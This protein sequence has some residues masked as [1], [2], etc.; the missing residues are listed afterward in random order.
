MRQQNMSM[1]VLQASILPF[2]YILE[3]HRLGRQPR[4]LRSVGAGQPCKKRLV[5]WHQILPRAPQG[6]LDSDCGC[7]KDIDL[8]GLNFL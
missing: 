5:A 7:Q 8:P 1:P 3:R 4:H 6:K 2:Q